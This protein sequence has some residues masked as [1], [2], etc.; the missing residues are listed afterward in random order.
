MNQDLLRWSIVRE[1][2]FFHF[3]ELA[4]EASKNLFNGYCYD[5][6]EYQDWVAG[7]RIDNDYDNYFT[8]SSPA[9]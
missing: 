8:D 2:K 1:K 7:G 4:K 9:W 3:S 5:L 6:E